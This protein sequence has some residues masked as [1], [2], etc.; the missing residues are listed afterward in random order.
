M[1]LLHGTIGFRL[2]NPK[3]KSAKGFI[4]KSIL[5]LVKNRMHDYIWTKEEVAKDKILADKENK[6]IKELINQCGIEIV[7][8]EYFYIEPK[9]ED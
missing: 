7:Q 5:E 1:N 4:W 3:L 8:E 6:G 2:G 9:E